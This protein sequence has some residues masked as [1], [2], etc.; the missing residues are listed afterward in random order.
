[1]KVLFVGESWVIHM[2]HTKG[3][4][5]FTSTKYEEGATFLLQCLREKGMDITYLPSHEVQIRFPSSVEELQQYDAVVLSDIGS[6]TFLLRNPTFYEMQVNPNPLELIKDYVA[7][8]GGFLMIGG[9]LSF[10]GIEGKANYKNTVLSELLPVELSD[11][12]DRIEMP[13]GVH[14]VTVQD[15]PLTN[16][17]G[18]WPLFLGYNRFAAKKDAKVLAVINDDPFLVSGNFGKGQTACFASDCAPHWGSK[19]FVDWKNY[20]LCWSRLIETIGRKS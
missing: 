11:T 19:E 20:P 17:L 2:I 1:M 16:D 9:Y 18:E 6:N 5:S 7:Q 13:Q 12:D 3:F 15:D 10:T 4:D 8:G 14:P